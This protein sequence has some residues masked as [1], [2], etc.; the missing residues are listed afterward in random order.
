MQLIPKP[1]CPEMKATVKGS[2]GLVAA[3]F[4]FLAFLSAPIIPLNGPWLTFGSSATFGGHVAEI[5][6]YNQTVVQFY[7]NGEKILIPETV[8]VTK[9]VGNVSV[10]LTGNGGL[11][12]QNPLHM[13]VTV[14]FAKD[15]FVSSG[16]HVVVFSPIG[17]YIAQNASF[18]GLSIPQDQP[19]TDSQ[20]LPINANITLTQQDDVW[21]GGEW[22]IYNQGCT[23]GLN[24]T[25]DNISFA[26]TQPIVIS[27]DDVT[28]TARTNAL[29]VSL[30]WVIIA[31]SALELRKK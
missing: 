19:E 14:Y 3:F 28:V 27:S 26:I 22:V 2:L 12:A 13:I 21:S 5:S 31:F 18:L 6:K 11:S 16:S 9:P 15:A 4:F 1:L 29:L 24:M 20:G 25:I 23:C 8:T 17:A 30:T 7:P 10:I